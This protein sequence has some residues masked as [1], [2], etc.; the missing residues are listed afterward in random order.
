MPDQGCETIVLYGIPGGHDLVFSNTTHPSIRK[1]RQEVYTKPIKRKKKYTVV[2]FAVRTEIPAF[3]IFLFSFW[4]FEAWGVWDFDLACSPEHTYKL[5]LPDAVG[6]MPPGRHKLE[7]GEGGGAVS[8]LS[9][10]WHRP[11]Q[12]SLWVT[13]EYYPPVPLSGAHATVA[14]EALHFRS[15]ADL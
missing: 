13:V 12:T 10:K 14:R 5:V 1:P 3:R 8:K 7:R 2:L 6:L 4:P 9:G 15:K 11:S